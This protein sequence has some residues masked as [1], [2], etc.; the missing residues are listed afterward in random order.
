MLPSSDASLWT[1]TSTTTPKLTGFAGLADAILDDLTHT[2]AETD[3]DKFIAQCVLIDTRLCEREVE[4]TRRPMMQPPSRSPKGPESYGARLDNHCC[5]PRPT[6]SRRKET[7]NRERPLPLFV[8]DLDIGRPPAHRSRETT[9]PSTKKLTGD[10]PYLDSS[11]PEAQYSFLLTLSSV[12][13]LCPN[14]CLRNVLKIFRILPF[15]IH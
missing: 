2:V 12:P 9:G 4:R 10:L 1:P 13:C 11:C 6:L 3:L 14:S 5:S 7:P 15:L 8:D